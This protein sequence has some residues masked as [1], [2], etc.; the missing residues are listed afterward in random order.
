MLVIWFH[1]S[2][3]GCRH[4]ESASDRRIRQARAAHLRKQVPRNGFRVGWT[5]TLSQRDPQ[6]KQQ[7]TERN[8]TRG[9]SQIM[10]QNLGAR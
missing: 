10:L 8:G 5:S 1:L 7:R 2:S 4:D 3:Y 9:R 6:Q